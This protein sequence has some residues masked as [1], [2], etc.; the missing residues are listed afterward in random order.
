MLYAPLLI[1]ILKSLHLID[2]QAG[3]EKINLVRRWG[4]P[5]HRNQA[6][7]ALTSLS[8]I[9]SNNRDHENC[10]ESNKPRLSKACSGSGPPKALSG[11]SQAPSSQDPGA[12]R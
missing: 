10:L 12:N 2:Q 6:S 1:I 5:I 3:L 7:K 4:Y 8:S 11:P 9:K